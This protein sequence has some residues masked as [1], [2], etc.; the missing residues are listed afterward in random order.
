MLTFSFLCNGYL[1]YLYIID[2]D[3]EVVIFAKKTVKDLKLASSS[4]H[5]T[6]CSIHSSKWMLET[7]HSTRVQHLNNFLIILFLYLF[8]YVLLQSQ[9]TE[10]RSLEGQDMY[11]GEK[12]VT[13]KVCFG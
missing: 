6:D 12:I 10:F 13:I 3:S 4:F 2:P 11:T 9:L 1:T 5:N 7:Q 8:D